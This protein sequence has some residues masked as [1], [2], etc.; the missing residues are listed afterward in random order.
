M[1]ALALLSLAV[2]VPATSHSDDGVAFVHVDVLP[3]DEEALLQD[4]TVL[5]RDGLIETVAPSGEVTVPEGMLVVD[6]AG[7]TLMPGL[8]D[9]HVHTWIP[10]E[11]AS[12]LVNGVAAEE[13]GLPVM[14][15]VPGRSVWRRCWNRDR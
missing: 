13:V 10:Q 15:H 6:G 7:K 11:H 12:F 4:Q 9:M 2:V 14:R 3:M 1:L 5:V 8:V